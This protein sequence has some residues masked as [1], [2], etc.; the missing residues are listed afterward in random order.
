MVYDLVAEYRKYPVQVYANMAGLRCPEAI[1]M[2]ALHDLPFIHNGKV[3]L[4]E[5]GIYLSSRYW[6]DVPKTVLQAFALGRKNGLDMYWT[7]HT[8]ERIDTVLREITAEVIYCH[9]VGS[10]IVQTKFQNGEKK[11]GR[12]RLIK[13]DPAIY[14]L[15]DTLELIGTNGGTQGRG[16]AATL[17]TVARKRASAEDN[18][19]AAVLRADS[20]PLF[21]F[22]RNSCQLRREAVAARDY[23]ISCGGWSDGLTWADQIQRELRRRRWLRRWGLKPEDAPY[24]TTPESPWLAGYSV[25]AV[26]ERRKQREEEDAQALLEEQAG[27]RARKRDAGRSGGMAFAT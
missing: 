16:A 23:L 15:Y 9:R 7:A 13:L 12:R 27:K 25:E 21:E 3:L 24:F 18:R 11:Q 19:R 2:E 1:Y 26:E 22:W 4:D 14:A 6:H 20:R 5:A 17:S 10:Y 8:V